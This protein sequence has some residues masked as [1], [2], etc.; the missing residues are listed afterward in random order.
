MRTNRRT[1]AM[2]VLGREALLALIGPGDDTRA[3]VHTYAYMYVA[4]A[5]GS[6]RS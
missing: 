6:H 2:Y 4:T 1:L 5:V 3:R